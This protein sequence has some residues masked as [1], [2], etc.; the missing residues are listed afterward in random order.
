M[1]LCHRR[2][3]ALSHPG[4][5]RDAGEV[6]EHATGRRRRTGG[7][8][9]HHRDLEAGHGRQDWRRQGQGRR[10]DRPRDRHGRGRADGVDRGLVL[11]L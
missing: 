2:A 10:V 1:P 3:A 5:A 7:E 4:L 11:F 9:R 8:H 6:E